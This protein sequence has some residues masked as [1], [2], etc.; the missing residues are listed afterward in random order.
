MKWWTEVVE[1]GGVGGVKWTGGVR[2]R[3]RRWVEV[4]QSELGRCVSL[5][6]ARRSE[7]GEGVE[8]W[9]R[10]VVGRKEELDRGRVTVGL[11]KAEHW[12][13]G[14]PCIGPTETTEDSNDR[15]GRLNT[16]DDLIG[17]LTFPTTGWSRPIH[18]IDHLH[19]Q[20]HK[21]FCHHHLLKFNAPLLFPHIHSFWGW[22]RRILSG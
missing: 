15:E 8:Q 18:P 7:K 16:S 6:V 17:L 14:A 11:L 10:G 19:F 3:G 20:N 2:R 22:R 5:A 4:G 21:Y 13:S 9:T 1:V 12:A